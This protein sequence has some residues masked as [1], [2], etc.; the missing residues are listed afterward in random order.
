MLQTRLSQHFQSIIFTVESEPLRKFMVCIIAS[1]IGKKDTCTNAAEGS[2]KSHSRRLTCCRPG[3]AS[4]FRVQSSQWN[5]SHCAN[6]WFASLPLRFTEMTH[7]QMQQKAV[8]NHI[9]DSWHAVDPAQPAVP[10][11]NL[12]GGSR[13]TAQ[14]HGLHRCLL[15]WHKKTHVQIQQKADARRLT[16]CRPGSASTFRV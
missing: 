6:S 1:E 13:A 3:S 14:I 11:Y 16:C 15:N 12:H 8:R 10:E 7:V 4:T 9:L 5:Q 2:Q